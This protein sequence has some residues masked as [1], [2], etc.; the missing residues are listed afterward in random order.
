LAYRP[1]VLDLAGLSLALLIGLVG[2]FWL[3]RTSRQ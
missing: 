2:S 1:D 3:R